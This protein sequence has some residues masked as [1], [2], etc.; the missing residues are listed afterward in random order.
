MRTSKAYTS[1]NGQ[2]DQAE[3]RISEIFEDQLN[4]IK[5]KA[6]SETKR[7]KI[8]K[9]SLQEILDYV[10]RPNLH[11]IGVPESDGENEIKLE[12]TLLDIIQEKFSNLARQANIQIQEI[13]RTAQRYSLRRATPD[14]YLSDPSGL[15]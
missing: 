3:E 6:S 1:F 4:E 11:L 9:Q 8:N 13:Q 10:K 2:I 7:V 14:T 12:N 15:K 5:R